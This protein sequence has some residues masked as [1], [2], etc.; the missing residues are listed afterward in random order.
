MRHFEV[1]RRSQFFAPNPQANP[2]KSKMARQGNMKN[3]KG[4]VH[5][6]EQ[7]LALAGLLV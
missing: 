5:F 2:G 1:R 4:P 6:Q 7:P 3:K